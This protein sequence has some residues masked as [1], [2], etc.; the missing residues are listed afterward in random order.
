MRHITAHRDALNGKDRMPQQPTDAT[1]HTQNQGQNKQADGGP[2]HEPHIHGQDDWFFH[3]S[4]FEALEC[5]KLAE[6]KR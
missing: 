4:P 1:G 6:A 5:S 3:A 2:L